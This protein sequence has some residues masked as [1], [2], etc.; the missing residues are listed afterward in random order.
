MNTNAMPEHDAI[1]AQ[2]VAPALLRERLKQEA[3]KETSVRQKGRNFFF[4]ENR[5]SFRSLFR[6]GLRL[7]GLLPRGRRNALN[8]QLNEHTLNVVGL[9]AAFDGYRILHLSDM[10]LEANVGLPSVLI[11]RIQGLSAD[12]CFISGDFRARSFGPITQ[13]LAQ[14]GRVVQHI[15]MPIYATL[16]NHDSIRMV[17]G[18]EALGIR[19]LLNES[20]VL[21]RG[22]DA[23][24]LVGADDPH[25]FRTDDLRAACADAPRDM[26]RILLVHSPEVIPEAAELGFAA[27]LC[28][29]THGGQICLPGGMPLISN[30]RAAWRFSSG[31]WQYGGMAGYTS[32]GSGVS[33]V[34]VR[35][36]CLPEV[37]VHT[38]RRVPG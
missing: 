20:V 16:G 17:P 8:L 36:N 18:I 3:S 31:P 7:S 13:C 15:D 38:L 9:P 30:A 11:E 14:L 6:A 34:D 10:H 2:R 19:V 23:V 33:I 35:Y 22:D 12:A 21:S 4:N 37:T 24:A 1:L 29:H 26:C 27:Y 28:G 5:L 32:R 25:Y